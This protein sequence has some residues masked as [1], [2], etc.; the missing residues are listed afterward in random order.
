MH[1]VGLVFDINVHGTQ[2]L[3]QCAVPEN[4]DEVKLEVSGAFRWNV[5]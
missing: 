2:C 1:F 5:P 4:E 3:S